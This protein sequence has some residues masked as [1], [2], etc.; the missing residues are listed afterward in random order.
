[1]TTVEFQLANGFTGIVDVDVL[2]ACS[3]AIDRAN[4]S[5]HLARSERGIVASLFW[6]VDKLTDI[7]AVAS[8]SSVE[9]SV[10][11]DN[12]GFATLANAYFEP[13]CDG[14]NF[15]STTPSGDIPVSYT[16]VWADGS[17]RKLWETSAEQLVV[18]LAAFLDGAIERWDH[19][20]KQTERVR[21]AVAKAIYKR[22][23]RYD[24]E[25]AQ[26]FIVAIDAEVV[27]S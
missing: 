12:I 20:P 24:A 13:T 10:H 1:M 6:T 17:P 8:D 22:V 27:L 15:R 26:R 25:L 14:S 2:R 18:A 19:N 9:I 23:K 4:M 21:L 3:I 5:N 7:W 16:P 11:V